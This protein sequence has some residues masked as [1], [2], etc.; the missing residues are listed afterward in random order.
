LVCKSKMAMSEPDNWNS[1]AY[2]CQICMQLFSSDTNNKM[3]PLVVC[4]NIHTVCR[5]CTTSIKETTTS[6][7]PQCRTDLWKHEVVNRDLIYFMNKL[8]LKCGGCSSNIKMSCS[9]AFKHS[10]ECLENHV[11]CPLLNN[12]PSLSRCNQTMSISNLWQH[13]I[14]YHS[15]SSQTTAIINATET[16]SSHDLTATLC[17]SITLDLN[18]YTFFQIQT[19]Y[20][21]YNMCMHVTKVFNSESASDDV[22][23]CFRRFFPEV[24]LSFG[25]IL[26]SVEVGDVCGMLLQVPSVV[27]AYESMQNLKDL[28]RSERLHKLLQVPCDLL[29][30]MGMD[31]TSHAQAGSANTSMMVSTQLFFRENSEEHDPDE[32]VA[33][34]PKRQCV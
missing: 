30:Q 26:I 2:R 14:Q 32:E 3:T 12:D 9:T 24:S 22:V 34:N 17:V 23:F 5:G 11:S 1:H 25:K 8:F 27:S 6:K 28:P 4:T 21:T 16:T 33:R 31:F 29:K 7:C 18:S 19:K 10:L 15:D 13:C 20:N